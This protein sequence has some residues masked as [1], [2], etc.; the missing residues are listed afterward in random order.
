[1]QM[2]EKN[3]QYSIIPLFEDHVEEVC[4]DIKRQVDKEMVSL[5]L[6]MMTLVPEGTPLL[7]K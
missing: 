6:F 1:M 7:I 4:Q 2:K 5:P 3:H